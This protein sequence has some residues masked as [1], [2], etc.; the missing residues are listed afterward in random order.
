[1]KR[2]P[3]IAERRDMRGIPLLAVGFLTAAALAFAGQASAATPVIGT[4][5]FNEQFIDEGASAACGFPVSV[6]LTGGGMYRVFLDEQ[7]NPTRIQVHTDATGTMSANGISL[8]E[9]DHNTD[10]IDLQAGTETLVGI[11][12]REFLPGL[13]IVIMDV[14]RVSGTDGSVTFE[15][16][17]HPALDGDLTRL[18]AALTP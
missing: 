13:G 10:F 11:V 1:M 16:G 3:R 5:Q 18:C 8:Q 15:A 6:D 17:P 4:F 9:V 14:G 7:G 2:R 12:F